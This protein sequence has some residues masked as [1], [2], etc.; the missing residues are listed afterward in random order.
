MTVF[1]S[2]MNEIQEG[3]LSKSTK[4]QLTALT[5]VTDLFVAGAGSHSTRQI[6]MFDEVFKTFVSVIELKARP[7]ICFR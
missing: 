6:E 1:D 7:S 2:L 4:R 3:Q 5:R